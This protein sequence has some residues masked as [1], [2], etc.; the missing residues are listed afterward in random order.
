MRNYY[1]AIDLGASGGRH[2]LSYLEDGKIQL[3]EV[4][5]FANG[6]K[7]IDG[8]KCWDVDLLFSEIKA[9]L[10]KCAEAGKIPASVGVDTWG[11][12]FVLLDKDGNR[13]GNV[14]GYRDSRT[15]GMDEEVYRLID[16]KALYAR[17]GIQKQIYNTIYQ[18]MAV[19]CR[20]PELLE[21]ADTILMMPD[22]FHYML[23]GKKAAEYTIAT[24]GQLVN[25]ETKNWDYELMDVLGYPKHIFP[26]LKMPGTV[27]GDLTPELQAEV[28]FNC[29]VV[30]PASHDT[31]SAVMA[32]PTTAEDTVYISSG[33]WSLM[34]VENKAANCSME[35][36]E[37]NFTNEGGY[38]YRYR[39][40]K[41]IMGLWMI[42][43][44]RHEYDDQYSFAELCAMADEAKDFPS[45]VDVD[46]LCFFAP[47]SMIGAIREYCARTNQAVPETPG[48]I[49]TVV[50]RSLA[51]CYGRTV[52]QIEGITGK[53]YD[54]INIVG[55]GSN[56][57]YLNRA[58]ADVTG[59]TVYAG[60]TEATAIGN[61]SAQM[62]AMGEFEC[63]EEVRR[64]IFASFG[65]KTY[66][67]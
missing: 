55:G 8:M 20:T 52:A 47:D 62:L 48:E 43:S 19:K 12:D 66:E 58:T 46:D 57:D 41:N 6:M 39:Y 16:E 44:V 49:S 59:R 9:G 15:Q 25:P 56:A 37:A 50:Y 53:R 27:L 11:V 35:S 63:L 45:R 40:L 60:P 2:I 65:V 3:E 29:K 14:V 54:S 36:Y 26:E 22:Y 33:T 42:Q 23:S 18:I 34:G 5:R 32:V 24:T 28:G 38:N 10:K 30:L 1:L 4:H 51:E 13:L 61:A 17:T 7:D 31:A 64:S 21:A 67:V